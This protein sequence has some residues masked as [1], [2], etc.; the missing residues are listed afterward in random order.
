M[1]SDGVNRVLDSIDGA[2][3]DYSTSSDAMRWVPPDDRVESKPDP[4]L[5]GWRAVGYVDIARAFGIPPSLLGDDLHLR[6]DAAPIRHRPAQPAS[7]TLTFTD[8]QLQA[9]A[10][11]CETI[12][13]EW[14]GVARQVLATLGRTPLRS[15]YTLWPPPAD[16]PRQRA[17][18]A[19]RNRNTGPPFPRLDQREDR[20]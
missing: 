13:T 12:F 17:L 7:F 5:V 1:S 11:M 9:L 18:D 14:A 15:D 6:F 2:L 10:R 8:E 19:R 16:D 20:R 4:D 3:E